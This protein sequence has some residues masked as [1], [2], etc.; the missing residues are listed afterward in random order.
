MSSLYEN[1]E[2]ANE[3]QSQTKYGFYDEATNTFYEV[4]CTLEEYKLLVTE[5]QKI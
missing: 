3:E 1:Q 5:F 2:E 4:A